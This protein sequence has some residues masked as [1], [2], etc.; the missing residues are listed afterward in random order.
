MTAAAMLEIRWLRGGLQLALEVIRRCESS[1][2]ID[3]PQQKELP[4]FV[5]KK[6]AILRA[7][8][9]QREAGLV[10]RQRVDT[11]VEDAPEQ[12]GGISEL[13]G[14]PLR[15][16]RDDDR[17]S[18]RPRMGTPRAGRT[19]R[20]RKRPVNQDTIAI[21]MVLRLRKFCHDRGVACTPG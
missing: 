21:R 17:T 3:V 14:T 7:R 4:A 20:R 9:T 2:V 10:T 18:G 8:V 11:I 19:V 16:L 15:R 1:R 6:R 13:D 5:S 12:A